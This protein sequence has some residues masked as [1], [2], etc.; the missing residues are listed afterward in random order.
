M[1]NENVGVYEP[2]VDLT[3]HASAA[4]TGK[5]FVAISGNRQTADNGG[6]ITVGVPAA[7][8]KV[9]GVSKYDAASGGKVGVMRGNSR[10]T[11]VT[12]A[13]NLTA[14]QEVETD[15]A[16]RAIVKASGVAVGFAV[17]AATSGADAEISLY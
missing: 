10:V 5:R 12:C 16:G 4:I 7:G 3:C 17:T 15:N 14:G 1:A 2:G 8:A 9:F 13:A 11:Y 6:N